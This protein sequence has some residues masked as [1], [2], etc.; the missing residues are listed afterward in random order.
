MRAWVGE[1]DGRIIGMGGIASSHGRWF[2][3]CDLKDEAR[4]YKRAI[5][6]AARTVMADAR[7]MDVAFVYAEADP[8]EPMS[9]R[10]LQ[11][12]GFERDERTGFLMRWQH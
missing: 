6:K 1:I 7:Q 2:A 4:K 9:V 12:L 5:V 8:E 11:S 10:W 3:F